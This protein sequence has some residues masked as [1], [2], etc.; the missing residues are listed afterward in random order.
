MDPS[1]LQQLP[2]IGSRMTPR[3]K[4][5]ILDAI[6]TGALSALDVCELYQI[7]WDELTEWQRLEAHFGVRALR[8]TRLQQYRGKT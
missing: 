1:I 3:R 6:E 7:S 8:T 5:T 2:P 4:A